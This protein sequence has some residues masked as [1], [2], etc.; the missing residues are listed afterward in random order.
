MD[1]VENWFTLGVRRLLPTPQL[2]VDVRDVYRELD[3]G[4]PVGR[5]WVEICMV[6]SVDGSTAVE[7]RSGALGHPTDSAV[8]RELRAQA[9]LVIVGSTTAHLERYGAPSKPGQRVGV[10]TRS[11]N[12]DPGLDVFRSGAGFLITTESAPTHGLDAV[13][14]GIDH[15]DLCAALE[16]LEAHVVH[17]EGGPVLNAAL[18]DAGVVDE[19]NVTISPTVIGGSSR[20]LIDGGAEVVRRYTLAHLYEDDGFLFARYVR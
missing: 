3:R 14:A 8:L 10:V 13:R 15:V 17:A 4:R 5:P 19:L 6:A 11:G 2:D 1:A 12:V 20:R 7:G 16:Q 18:L 9:D